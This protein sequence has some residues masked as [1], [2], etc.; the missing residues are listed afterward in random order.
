MELTG[1]LLVLV[2]MVIN[3]FQFTFEERLLARYHIEPLELVG[4]EGV[5]GLIYQTLV[6]IAFSFVP[7]PDNFGVEACV[8]S[9][10]GEP[11]LEQPLQYF[12]QLGASAV[13]MVFC[14][15]GMI[16]IMLYNVLGVSITKYIN[17]L[18]RSIADVTRTVLIWG[19]GLLITAT[20][21]R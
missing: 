2:G 16:S 7:C 10:D 3:G 17:A 9:P 15:V 8:F 20:E 5:F 21:G 13:L 6:V 11:F 14:I 1:Y 12:R 19:V 18:A 4:Y